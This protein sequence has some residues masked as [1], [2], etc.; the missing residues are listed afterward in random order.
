MSEWSFVTDSE[1]GGN[2]LYVEE[3]N[4]DNGDST[5][6]SNIPMTDTVEALKKRIATQL[7]NAGAWENLALFAADKTLTNSM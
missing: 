1:T 5:R 4:S 3:V 6:L 7:G 2:F